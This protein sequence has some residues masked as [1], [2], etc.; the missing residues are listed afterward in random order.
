MRAVIQR[1][2][3]ASVSVDNE[4]ISQISRGLMVL[5]GIGADDTDAD[6]VTICNKVLSL[7]VFSDP[8]NPEKMWRVSVKDIDGD[9]LCVS[10]FTLLANTTK[11]NKPDFHRAMA[12]EPSREL[13][14]S[15]LEKLKHLYQPDKIQDGRFGAMMNISLTNEGPVTFTIDSRKFEYVD[16]PNKAVGVSSKTTAS[17]KVPSEGKTVEQDA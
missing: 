11:G 15:F 9:I 6:V 17:R 1:V 4:V 7:R 16:Q 12:T 10:Q 3:S 8:A 14:L 2:T 13:Y 5:V